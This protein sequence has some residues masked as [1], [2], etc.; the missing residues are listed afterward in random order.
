[1]PRI[2]ID[3]RQHGILCGESVAPYVAIS[4][5]RSRG[6][7][8]TSKGDSSAMFGLLQ[9]TTST[10]GCLPRES[11]SVCPYAAPPGDVTTSG[12]RH[13]VEARQVHGCTPHPH[14]DAWLL[15]RD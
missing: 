5:R 10:A 9:K 3:S 12:R 6:Y 11:R 14:Q 2:V 13:A 4:R 8:S 15:S 7:Q 1:M